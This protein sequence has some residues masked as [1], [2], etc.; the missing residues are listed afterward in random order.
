MVAA[1]FVHIIISYSEVGVV[2][3]YHSFNVGICGV[4]GVW[5]GYVFD[6]IKICGRYL[7]GIGFFDDFVFDRF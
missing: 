6:G 3:R 4:V 1:G 7:D 2:F 5:E